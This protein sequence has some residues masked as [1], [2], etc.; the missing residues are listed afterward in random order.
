VVFREAFFEGF[1]LQGEKRDRSVDRVSTLNSL[2]LGVGYFL[3]S[4]GIFLLKVI[5][6]NRFELICPE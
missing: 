2:S 3:H 4:I 5:P 6:F 1:S